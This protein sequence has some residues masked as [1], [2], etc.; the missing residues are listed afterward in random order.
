MKAR[1][2]ADLDHWEPIE[3]ME[4][5]E[6]KHVMC[7]LSAKEFIALATMQVDQGVET[8]VAML[9]SAYHGC[10]PIYLIEGL[11]IWMRKNKTAENRAY[12]AKVNSLTQAEDAPSAS[13]P[14]SRRKKPAAETIDEDLIE[15]SLLRLQV[16]N[17]CLVHHTSTSVESAEWVANFT[18]HI[19]TIP[20][21]SVIHPSKSYNRSTY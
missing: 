14:A 21:R 4:I 12:Q 6:E 2:N 19:S 17:N 15:D 9:K 11:H 3:H 18:Q 1:W 8:H 20:Y 5:H 13:Q 7:L 10:V 16:M